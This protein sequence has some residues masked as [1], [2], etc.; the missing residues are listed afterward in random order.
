MGMVY[1]FKKVH[2][3]WEFS[4]PALKKGKDR[5]L[6]GEIRFLSRLLRCA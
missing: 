1:H 3:Q 5:K 2:E 6:N 4:L